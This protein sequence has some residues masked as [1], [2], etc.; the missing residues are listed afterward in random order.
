MKI[1]K[2]LITGGTGFIGSWT[3][4]LLVRRG[5]EIIVLDDLEPQVHRNK[6]PEYC[7]A[8]V[9]CVERYM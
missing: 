9:K 7:N 2:V 8:Y 4:D 1:R 3:T 6:V 5:Y